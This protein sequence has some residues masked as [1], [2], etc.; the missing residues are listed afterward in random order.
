MTEPVFASPTW[1]L[2]VGGVVVYSAICTLMGLRARPM[3]S[4]IYC[5]AVGFILIVS[6]PLPVS[7]SF[8]VVAV[9]ATGG[10]LSSGFRHGHLEPF[11]F[12]GGCFAPLLG[13]VA[14]YYEG[15]IQ[16]LIA[17][18]LAVG[19]MRLAPHLSRPTLFVVSIVPTVV[20]VLALACP[21]SLM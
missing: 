19:L 14:A 4:A 18:A 2:W 6:S 8:A 1:G 12:L 13:L 10:W 9:P 5:I 15:W 17:A 7:S 16:M 20:A 11:Q 3:K 21:R